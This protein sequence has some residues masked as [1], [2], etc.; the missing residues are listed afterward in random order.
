[1]IRF[2]DAAVL[3][4]TKLRTRKIRTIITIGM[5]SILFSVLILATLVTGGIIASARAFTSGNL[6]ER[7]I[8]HVQYTNDYQT[9]STSPEVKQRANQLHAQLVADK[10]AAAKRLGVDYDPN[11]EPKPVQTNG[12]GSEYLDTSSP[13]ANQALKEYVLKQPTTLDKAKK[14][15]APYHPKQFYPLRSS[16]IAGQLKLMKAGKEDF[17]AADPRTNPGQAP[18]V[19]SG[20]SYLDG[21]ITKSFVLDNKQL[22]AQKG[23]SDLPVIAPYSKV[24]AALGLAKLPSTAS[25]SERLN[26]VTYVREHAA[27]ARFTVCYRNEASQA[28]IAAAL[29]TAKEIE[30]NKTNKNYQKPSLI[31]GLPA[32]D[33]CGAAP[34]V[35]DTR[36]K[37][38]KQL[39]AKQDQF[40][41]MFGKVVE[42]AEEKVTFRVVGIAP[43]ALT[44]ENFS[45]ISLLVLAVAGS[46]L[47]GQWVV[48]QDMYDQ[49]PA[50][51]KADYDKFAPNATQSAEQG[52]PE[53]V[54]V[55]FSKPE[56]IK[57]FMSEGCNGPNCTDKPFLMYFGSNSVL[58]GD[59][60]TIV[61][62]V[63]F[64]AALIVAAIASLIMMGMISRVISDSRRET[65]VFRAIG[66]KR[67]DIRTIYSTYTFFLSCCVVVVTLLLGTLGA[68]W[69]DSRWS[70]D[71]TI[72]AQLVFA[73]RDSSLQFHLVGWWWTPILLISGLIL[74]TGFVGMLL[75]LMRNLVRSPIK[76]MRDD[77]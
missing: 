13:A 31:Y 6:S 54:L 48:P 49:L 65:A 67:S 27:S 52:A 56:D 66:A 4:A 68:V 75:P 16:S 19:D 50:S 2:S 12:Q 23:S 42:P 55:E 32:A 51:T 64:V 60:V 11:T 29:S 20:W 35:S 69:I 26:R 76:D 71:A 33:S 34:V 25:P 8:T 73:A 28:Q 63:L 9:Y 44:F 72:Q 22:V 10:T 77:T 17:S 53:G 45:S 74:L 38:E 36:T 70:G 14:L 1:M 46:S 15:A 18:D 21:S 40:N 7:Y 43:D 59:I 57:G 3:A 30:E 39:A 62:R 24:E 61:G 47:Q 41:A 5:V 37:A 58:I